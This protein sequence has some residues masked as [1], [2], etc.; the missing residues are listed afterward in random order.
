MNV[1]F[2]M[3][4]LHN[5]P[6]VDRKS[7][8][9]FPSLMIAVA[10]KP[11]VSMTFVGHSIALWVSLH[12]KNCLFPS[13]ST[14]GQHGVDGHLVSIQWPS[15][16]WWPSCV[17][18]VVITLLPVVLCRYRGPHTVDGR[19]V[20]IQGPPHCWRPFC[21]KKVAL[22]LL[23]AVLCRY[24]GPHNVDGRVVSIQCPPHCWRSSC[25]DTVA[26]RC[27]RSS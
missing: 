4:L 2:P 24:S 7:F 3:W 17:D 1:L 9:P 22:T 11:V 15:H 18:I 26:P 14:K 19:L 10:E 6:I 5:Q 21:V 8:V 16:C 27:W 20:P 23:I 25:V 13:G 12:L